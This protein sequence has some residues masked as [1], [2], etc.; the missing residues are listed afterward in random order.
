M[1]AHVVAYTRVYVHAY[2]TVTSVNQQLSRLRIQI[3]VR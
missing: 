1:T 3:K 2:V